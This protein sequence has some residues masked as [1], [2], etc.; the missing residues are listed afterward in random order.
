M[1]SCKGLRMSA[2]AIERD[3]AEIALSYRLAVADVAVPIDRPK[4][5]FAAELSVL[6]GL[7]AGKRHKGGGRT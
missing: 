7:G 4:S 1:G 3:A 5:T 2:L 6:D